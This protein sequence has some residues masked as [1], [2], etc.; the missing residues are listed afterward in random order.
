M[1]R[2]VWNCVWAPW[3]S[4][5]VHIERTTAMS[6]TQL[7]MCGNQSLT[8]MPLWPY[9][10]EADLQRI[11]LVALLAVGVVDDD[12]RASLSFSGFCASAYGV[13]LIDLPAYLVSSGLG[14]N[15]SMWRQPPFMNSQMTLLALGVK[16]G[17][18][19]GGCQASGSL[20]RSNAV[21]GQHRAECQAGEAQAEVGEERA[22]RR[23]VTSLG[24]DV[25]MRDSCEVVAA[26]LRRREI[27]RIA[28]E[29]FRAYRTVMKSLWL[30]SAWT[31]LT[32]GDGF[33]VGSVLGG[34]ELGHATAGVRP[35]RLVRRRLVRPTGSSRRPCG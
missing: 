7:P 4:S 24:A 33:R 29:D 14:S 20:A 3:L 35:S 21:L 17:W 1:C 27:I 18:P 13:S 8:S 9:F 5:V 31:R 25:V 19:S 30:R 16:C 6:S 2:P 28:A 11:E 10:L 12:T 23:R 32:R 22:A 34:R 15:V 26:S